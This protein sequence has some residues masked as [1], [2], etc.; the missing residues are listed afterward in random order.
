M[1]YLDTSV[2]LAHLFAEDRRPPDELWDERLVASRLLA[3]ETW[4]RVHAR[5]TAVEAQDAVRAVLGRV[6][7]LELTP[8]VLARALDAFPVPVRT[9]D[10][11]H[12]ASL[13]FLRA[14]GHDVAIA[15]Y[16]H[17]LL[18]AAEALGVARSLYC[19]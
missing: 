7:M 10:A 1:I 15:A 12:L 19:S 16:D 18:D 13:E 14:Q 6:A 3:Y 8:H 9:L 4:T 11:L 17:R 2:V 5:R